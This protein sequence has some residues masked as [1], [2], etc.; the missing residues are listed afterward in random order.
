[1]RNYCLEGESLN[2]NSFLLEFLFDRSRPVEKFVVVEVDILIGQWV[3]L[4]CSNLSLCIGIEIIYN[5]RTFMYK[6]RGCK[7]ERRIFYF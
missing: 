1:M 6:F 4:L 5:I 3:Q 7:E 2:D